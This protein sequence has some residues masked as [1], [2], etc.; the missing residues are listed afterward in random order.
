WQKGVEFVD[1][2]FEIGDRLPQR[3]QFSLGEQLRRAALSITNNLAE[4]SG[5]RTP[6]SQRTFYDAAKGSV[7]EVVSILAIAL[8]RKEITRTEYDGTYRAGDELASII[9]GLI[10]ATLREETARSTTTRTLREDDSEYQLP[11][12]DPE[13]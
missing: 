4:G 8:R 2:M 10:D 9:S 11:H 13:P 1:R 6:G 7:Y 3:L 12:P 5:R